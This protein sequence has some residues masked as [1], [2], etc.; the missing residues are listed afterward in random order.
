MA[1]HCP[2]IFHSFSSESGIG[3]VRERR[4]PTASREAAENYL[5]SGK[6]RVL[7]WCVASF[8]ATYFLTR[9]KGK[10]IRSTLDWRLH[11]DLRI[12]FHRGSKSPGH[13]CPLATG[14]LTNDLSSHSVTRIC[15]I[16]RPSSID[17]VISSRERIPINSITN[18]SSR[19]FPMC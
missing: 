19:R 12:C 16:V 1:I 10:C 2:S 5:D 15:R 6:E 9:E 11:F 8:L 7:R 4:V 17:C 18:H 3:R 14:F 13:A